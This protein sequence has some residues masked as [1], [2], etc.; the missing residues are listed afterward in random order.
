MASFLSQDLGLALVAK[1]CSHR[2]L[3]FEKADNGQAFPWQKKCFLSE[4]IDCRC[5]TACL[6]KTS[7][8][9]FEALTA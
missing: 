8:K 7:P 5:S 6:L 4:R 3:A 2:P 9:I 1:T